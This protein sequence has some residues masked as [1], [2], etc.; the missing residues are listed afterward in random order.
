[1]VP[2][3]LE[4]FP[5]VGKGR[6]EAGGGNRGVDGSQGK[7]PWVL[8]TRQILREAVTKTDCEKLRQIRP[9]TASK[10]SFVSSQV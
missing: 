5:G 8:S 7:E 1:M 4:K 3:S 9:P 10:I 2:P 6:Q